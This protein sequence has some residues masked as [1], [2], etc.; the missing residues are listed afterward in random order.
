[1]SAPVRVLPASSDDAAW[2]APGTVEAIAGVTAEVWPC[3]G[4]FVAEPHYCVVDGWVTDL[5]LEP[6]FYSGRP[7]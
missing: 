6:E 1:M 4:Q 2:R 7:L 5:G 3:C